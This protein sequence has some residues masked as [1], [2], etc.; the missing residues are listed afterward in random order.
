VLILTSA[1]LDDRK[2][3]F[4]DCLAHLAREAD[5][6]IWAASF[7]NPA[8]R[9]LWDKTPARVEAFPQVTPVRTL[10]VGLLRRINDAVW[11][12]HLGLSSRLSFRA[13]IADARADWRTRLLR[14]P[15][16]LLARLGIAPQL[17]GLVHAL[18][19]RFCRSRD[20]AARLQALAPD[21]VLST[22]ATRALE[23]PV[24]TEA[25]RAGTPVLSLIHSWDS[26]TTKARLL[27][28]LDGFLVWS[29][30]M[31]AE[32]LR[33]Y[34]F[35]DPAT[36]Y[37]VGAQQFDVF[38]QPRFQVARE[39]FLAAHGLASGRRVIT[40]AL[41]SP[42]LFPEEWRAARRLAEAMRDGQ[43]EN[44]QLLVRP[45]PQFGEGRIEA[46][47]EGLPH[48]RIQKVPGRERAFTERAQDE[49]QIRDWVGTFRHTDVLVNLSST[50][51]I[52]ACLVD[53]PVVNL[54]FD[55]DPARARQ[56]LVKA[57]NHEWE[58]FSPVAQ[59][60]GLRLVADEDAMVAAVQAY[61]E[62]P[63]ADAA[64]RGQA[65]AYVCGYV[66]GRCG[67]RMAEAVLG[68][69]ASREAPRTRAPAP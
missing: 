37:V 29:P 44:A 6:T 10:P 63:G 46:H 58:H 42:R 56:A 55:P 15:G 14:S 65:A 20:V 26:L 52:D 50:A 43:I 68:F 40:Y 60:G 27:D 64:G 47:F 67:V 5:V 16:R 59:S 32:L 17:E 28:P 12:H 35:A 39:A 2:L 25:R 36:V 33:V 34:P 62:H 13:L 69:L 23:P 21:V 45:H 19:R 9:P 4:N 48:V 61:L 3:L 11:D 57:V 51:A 53:T 24:L 1:L 22:G 41:G 38:F 8:V 31:R 18:T 7:A 54:D 66:D 49:A 30:Q